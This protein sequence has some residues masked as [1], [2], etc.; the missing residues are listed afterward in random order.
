MRVWPEALQA[1]QQQDE[2]NTGVDAVQGFELSRKHVNPL[3][4]CMSASIEPLPQCAALNDYFMD[5]Y[6]GELLLVS[7]A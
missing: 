4:D 2:D 1:Y 7:F 3:C 5:L 6:T